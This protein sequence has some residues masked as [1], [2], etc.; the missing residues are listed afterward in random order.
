MLV[1]IA[2][3]TVVF[4]I[5]LLSSNIALVFL[6]REMSKLGR[7]ELVPPILRRVVVNNYRDDDEDDD[8]DDIVDND[9]NR[10]PRVPPPTPLLEVV[11]LPFE[12]MHAHKPLP[13]R[14]IDIYYFYDMAEHWTATYWSMYDVLNDSEDDYALLTPLTDGLDL[15]TVVPMSYD[16]DE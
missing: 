12:F 15:D 6:F 2:I 11:D 9:D 5:L 4:L 1:I 10:T 7:L 14:M 3:I 16:L 8:E 13:Y